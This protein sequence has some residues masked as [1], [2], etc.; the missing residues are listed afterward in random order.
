[1]YKLAALLETV[2][3][4][5]LKV[6]HGPTRLG[7]ILSN[8]GDP[9]KAKETLHFRASVNLTEGLRMLYEGFKK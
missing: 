5:S 8:Y 1:M 6:R 9:A 7:D 3:G 4:K 2:T